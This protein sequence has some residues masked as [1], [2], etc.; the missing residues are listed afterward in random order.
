MRKCKFENSFWNGFY[1]EDKRWNMA[2]CMG[3]WHT[4]NSLSNYK[5]SITKPF[6]TMRY[7]EPSI[8]QSEINP[9]AKGMIVVYSASGSF[10]DNSLVEGL[11]FPNE[12]MKGLVSHHINLRHKHVPYSYALLTLHPSEKCDISPKISFDVSVLA[13]KSLL[14]LYPSLLPKRASIIIFNLHI[15]IKFTFNSQN[16]LVSYQYLLGFIFIISSTYLNGIDINFI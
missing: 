5:Q 14:F 11:S 9:R 4:Y 13:R 15:K 6:C 10:L 12:L 7:I 16:W 3:R 8:A 2:W 1:F